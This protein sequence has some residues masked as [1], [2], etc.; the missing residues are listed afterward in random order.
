MPDT[1]FL[2]GAILL[3][4]IIWYFYHR[5]NYEDAQQ[6]EDSILNISSNLDPINLPGSIYASRP[7]PPPIPTDSSDFYFNQTL[8]NSKL[9]PKQ[10]ALLFEKKYSQY[11][12]YLLNQTLNYPE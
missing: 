4:L 11:E 2:I 5:E 7:P 1:Y 8:Q 10:Q 6:Q 3:V 12:D 9:T